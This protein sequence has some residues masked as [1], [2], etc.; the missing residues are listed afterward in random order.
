MIRTGHT[1]TVTATEGHPLTLGTRVLV[2]HIFDDGIARVSV[3]G[4]AI[5]HVPTTSLEPV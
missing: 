4:H 1:A 5:V 3:R 2:L